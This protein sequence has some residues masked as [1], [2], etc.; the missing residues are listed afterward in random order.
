LLAAQYDLDSVPAMKSVFGALFP[1][2]ASLRAALDDR[3]LWLLPSG[4]T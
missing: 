1:S 3:R 4:G 2:D